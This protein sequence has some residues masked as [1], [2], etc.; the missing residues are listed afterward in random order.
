[1]KLKEDVLSIREIAPIHLASAAPKDQFQ[2]N[3][4]NEIEEYIFK[5][6]STTITLAL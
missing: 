6:R 2:N 3:F 5:Y 4:F 1:M